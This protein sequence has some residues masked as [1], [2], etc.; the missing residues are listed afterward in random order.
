MPK[1]A[2][3]DMDHIELDELVDMFRQAGKNGR[4]PTQELLADLPALRTTAWAKRRVRVQQQLALRSSEAEQALRSLSNMESF[5]LPLVI[6]DRALG[7]MI[8]FDDEDGELL[9]TFFQ[10]IPRLAAVIAKTPVGST[11]AAWHSPAETVAMNAI[12]AWRLAGRKVIGI[13]RNSPLAAFTQAWLARAG[14]HHA[15]LS[16]IAKAFSSGPV[17]RWAKHSFR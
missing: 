9:R 12:F 7:M 16:A 3:A 14:V 4:N 2:Q 1:A 17:K 8:G 6:S 5:L 10:M 15:S 11:V 13:D